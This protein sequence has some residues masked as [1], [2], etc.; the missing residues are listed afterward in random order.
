MAFQLTV[1]GFTIL[2]LGGCSGDSKKYEDPVSGSSQ[3]IAAGN[4]AI[5][6]GTAFFVCAHNQEKTACLCR[7]Q[8]NGEKMSFS[9]DLSIGLTALKE[10]SQDSIGI[11]PVNLTEDS[12]WHWEITADEVPEDILFIAEINRGDGTYSSYVSSPQN[13]ELFEEDSGDLMLI[14]EKSYS[15]STRYNAV[16]ILHTSIT[17]FPIRVNPIP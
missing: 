16:R 14:A 1:L 10:S 9:A 2:F 11:Q 15:P 6:D 8:Q 5:K 12:D 3:D 4:E 17:R 7:F 13:L